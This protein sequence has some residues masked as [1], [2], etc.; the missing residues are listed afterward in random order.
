LYLLTIE[1]EGAHPFLRPV[2]K[3]RS[4]DPTAGTPNSPSKKKGTACA[5]PY[6]PTF[7]Y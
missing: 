4:Y 6:N 5:V 1:L 3:G 2:K 7:D